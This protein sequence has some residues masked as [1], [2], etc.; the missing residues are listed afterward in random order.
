MKKNWLPFILFIIVFTNGCSETQ[1]S[2]DMIEFHPSEYQ[3][4]LYSNKTNLDV[5]EAYVD[6]ILTLKTYYSDQTKGIKMEKTTIHS[7]DNEPI[8]IDQFPTLLI[9][10]NGEIIAK[11]SGQKK[12]S[13]ILKLIQEAFSNEKNPIFTN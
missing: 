9:K 11:I 13:D 8:D 12:K 2:I 7:M 1:A 10:K 4:Q 3:V 6:A 5:E